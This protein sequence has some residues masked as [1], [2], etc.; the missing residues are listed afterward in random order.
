MIARI[1]GEENELLRENPDFGVRLDRASIDEHLSD[2]RESR[3]AWMTEN[4]VIYQE[5]QSYN[6]D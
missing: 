6:D 4:P 3:V 5:I 2:I 1:F